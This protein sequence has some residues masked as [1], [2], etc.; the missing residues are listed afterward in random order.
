MV[1]INRAANVE[2]ERFDQARNVPS[3]SA[4]TESV[5]N[6]SGRRKMGWFGK[7]AVVAA[8]AI[9]SIDSYHYIKT[10]EVPNKAPIVRIS[11]NNSNTNYAYPKHARHYRHSTRHVAT[12]APR[13]YSPSE[14]VQPAQPQYVQQAAPVPAPQVSQVPQQRYA[15]AQPQQVEQVQQPCANV[16]TTSWSGGGG[17]GGG[18]Q[19]GVNAQMPVCGRP[20]DVLVSQTL[21]SNQNGIS[22]ANAMSKA[23]IRRA[24]AIADQEY[25]YV[26][27]QAAATASQVASTIKYLRR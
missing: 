13:A 20:Y 3:A 11:N 14:N 18:S 12:P 22:N 5:S 26:A 27:Q 7:T 17:F 19:A 10:N 23:D 8:L 2:R 6:D 4:P 24:N 1:T 16:Q 25:M 9:A 21:Q 15:E